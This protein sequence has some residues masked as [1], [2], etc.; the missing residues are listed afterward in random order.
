MPPGTRRSTGPAPR[1]HRRVEEERARDLV[2]GAEAVATRGETGLLL[3][4]ERRAR[5]DPPGGGRAVL[6]GRIEHGHRLLLVLDDWLQQRQRH[7]GFVVL[8]G[9]IGDLLARAADDERVEEL[10]GDEVSRGG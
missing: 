6:N 9:A 1:D 8:R 3:F 4:A 10:I 2:V 5:C 7:A